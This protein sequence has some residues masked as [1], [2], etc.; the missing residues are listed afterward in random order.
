VTPS[1]TVVPLHPDRGDAATAATLATM[2][3]LALDASR[4]PVVLDTA[5]RAAAVDREG[6]F[7]RARLAE[8]I[9]RWLAEHTRYVPDPTTLE[10]VRPPRRLLDDIRL[11]G[12]AAEDC[13]GLATLH[14]AMLE[15]V[16]VPTRFRVLGR[17]PAG[18]FEHVMVDA[19]TERG[20]RSYDV[21]ARDLR[22]GEGLAEAPRVAVWEDRMMSYALGGEY[23]EPVPVESQPAASWSSQAMPMPTT[24]TSR[25]VGTD[26]IDWT[27]VIG[28]VGT[29]I[30]KVG[31]A[32]L[33]FLERYGVLEPVRG[34]SRLPLPG[35]PGYAYAAETGY[36]F[37]Y[38][39]R[40]VQEMPAWA[41]IALGGGLLLL[42]AR[43]R[44][45]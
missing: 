25:D 27:G 12:W 2:R 18:P 14:A 9:T 40:T 5:R 3:R 22:L 41:W 21:A 7:S 10:V 29:G 4:D 20:W 8:R 13:E 36:P 45:A 17:S 39:R 32:V 16:G 26:R 23:W 11:Q 1:L 42:L 34:P 6:G 31:A 24:G 43:R 37:T 28:A 38:V 44:R 19:L 35:E 15:A 30:A 33:P